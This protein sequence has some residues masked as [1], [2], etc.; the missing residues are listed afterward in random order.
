MGQFQL[1]QGDLR[2]A[3]SSFEQSRAAYEKWGA[4]TLVDRMDKLIASI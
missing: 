2:N 3:T 1:Y 4:T